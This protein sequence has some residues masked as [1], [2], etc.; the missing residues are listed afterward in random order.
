MSKA[1]TLIG[2]DYIL[3]FSTKSKEGNILITTGST[4]PEN[5]Y[6]YSEIII[7]KNDAED[8]IEWLKLQMGI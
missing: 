1:F 6:A 2:S 5:I 4:D 8:I 7:S 3:S